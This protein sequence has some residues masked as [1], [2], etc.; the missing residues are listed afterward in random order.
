MAATPSVFCAVTAVIALVPYTPNAA[1]V[2]KSAWMPAPPPES[3][4]AMVRATRRSLTAS[5]AEAGLLPNTSRYWNGWTASRAMSRR[6]AAV[7]ALI[8]VC[9]IDAL[10]GRRAWSAAAGVEIHDADAAVRLERLR[11]LLQQLDGIGRRQFHFSEGF[12]DDDRVDALGQSRIVGRAENRAHPRQVLLLHAPADPI[13]HLRL[14]VLGVDEAVRP[15]AT[16]EPDGKPA[17][18]APSSA[19]TE[20]SAIRRASMICSGF[21]H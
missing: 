15:D 7:A 4:P 13:D 16:R 9:G 19:T 1:N 14:N 18:A 12:D 3:L 11:S 6:P 5:T 8:T 2:F 10:L 17:A 21:C 20:P